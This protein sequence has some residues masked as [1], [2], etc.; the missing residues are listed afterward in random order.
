ML[1]RELMEAHQAVAALRDAVA[2]LS[3]DLDA[4]KA[5]LESVKRDAR[6]TLKELTQEQQGMYVHVH[7][8][9]SGT[10]CVYVLTSCAK[11]LALQ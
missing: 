5:Q 8:P 1:D 2:T 11:S 10:A 4:A 3:Q 6:D 7:P 9:A